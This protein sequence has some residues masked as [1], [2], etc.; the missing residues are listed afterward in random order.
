MFYKQSGAR[1]RVVDIVI[2]LKRLE[3]R[4]RGRHLKVF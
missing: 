1:S 4:K 3:R 2:V